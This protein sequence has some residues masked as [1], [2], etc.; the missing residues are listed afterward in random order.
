MGNYD[1]W[2][3]FDPKA[4]AEKRPQPSP[5]A[6]TIQKNRWAAKPCIL[7]ESGEIY[8]LALARKLNAV[9]V[10]CG[11][12]FEAKRIRELVIWQKAGL[13]TDLQLQR[14]F[15]LSY[16]STPIAIVIGSYIAD[17]CYMRDGVFVVEDAKGMPG[18]SQLYQWK[19]KHFA[20][21]Y[22][23]AITEVSL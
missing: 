8:E 12:L 16:P 9:G 6:Q 18:R 5:T 10:R 7:T 1:G 23:F 14:S 20:A 3:D 22:G 4:H 17:A 19:K 15:T 21:Q 13:I 2:R 11:S